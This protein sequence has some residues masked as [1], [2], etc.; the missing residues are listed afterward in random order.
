MIHFLNHFS[1]TSHKTSAKLITTNRD[2]IP[3]LWYYMYIDFIA[4][5]TSIF[6]GVNDAKLILL[7][8]GDLDKALIKVSP[9]LQRKLIQKPGK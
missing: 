2:I 4:L 6:K 3:F 5:L 8:V 1:H 9:V 7:R